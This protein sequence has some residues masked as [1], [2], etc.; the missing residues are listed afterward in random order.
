GVR[1]TAAETV[2][3]LKKDPGLVLP[4]LS[5]AIR[6]TDTDT[7]VEV[8]DRGFRMIQV[9]PMRLRALRVLMEMGP[10][11]ARAV[12]E[13]IEALQDEDVTIQRTAT[14]ALAGIGP[15][16]KDAM[17]ALINCL[18]IRKGHVHIYS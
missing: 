8:R 16:A 10:P 11:A 12:P 5:D 15:Q 1:L 4:I 14:M 17:P 13:L 7:P 6:Q 2:W 9:R 3:R 18:K